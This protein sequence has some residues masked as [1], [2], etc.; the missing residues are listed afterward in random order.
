[1]SQQQSP[2]ALPFYE[3]V[4][5][6]RL[7]RGWTRVKLA[8]TAKVSRGTIDNWK[9]QP[10]APLAPTVTEVADRLGIDR[11]EALRL[12]GI[13]RAAQGEADATDAGGRLVPAEGEEEPDDTN[14]FGLGSEPP[15]PEGQLNAAGLATPQILNKLWAV[16]K[17]LEADYYQEH[18]TRS[19]RQLRVIKQWE[20]ATE[21]LIEELGDAG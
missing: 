7:E 10:R 3:R 20:L 19:E 18:G 16:A 11:D 17:E 9:S 13:T 6:I 4:E 12:A 15:F 21:A 2:P 8:R 5:Q 1:M 14:E